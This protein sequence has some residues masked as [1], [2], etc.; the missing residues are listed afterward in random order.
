MTDAMRL[1]DLDILH[2]AVDVLKD[3]FERHLHLSQASGSHKVA[4][5]ERGGV[6]APQMNRLKSAVNELT[7]MVEKCL[8]QVKRIDDA[9]EKREQSDDFLYL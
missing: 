3:R 8:K 7:Q 6:P 4:A 2:S 5:R 1:H 9:V